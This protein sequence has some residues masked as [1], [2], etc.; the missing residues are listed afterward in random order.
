MIHFFEEFLM[1]KA[2]N[3]NNYRWRNRMGDLEIPIDYAFLEEC[4]IFGFHLRGEV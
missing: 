4:F 1:C 2:K 3:I